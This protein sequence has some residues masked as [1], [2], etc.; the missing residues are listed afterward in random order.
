MHPQLRSPQRDDHCRL[1]P[2]QRRRRAC[3]DP[4]LAVATSGRT[5]DDA[6]RQHGPIQAGASHDGFISRAESEYDQTMK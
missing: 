5:D 3:T 2:G 4:L 6:I 1:G